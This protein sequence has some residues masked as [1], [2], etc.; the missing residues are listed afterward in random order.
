MNRLTKY[1]ALLLVLPVLLCAGCAGKKAE[2]EHTA[3]VSAVETSQSQRTEEVTISAEVLDLLDL[4]MALTA[5]KLGLDTVTEN[6][7]GSCTVYMTE[8]E[9]AIILEQ[10]ERTLKREIDA[11]PQSGLWPFL[12]K[13]A[14]SEDLKTVVLYTTEDRYTPERDSTIAP[15]VYLPCLLYKAFSGE[16]TDRFK[17][18]F[19]IRN[20]DRVEIDSFRY[21]SPAPA[22]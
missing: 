16:N 22:E 13:I 2:A 21:P 11:L 14:V 7:D 4:D 8:E 6:E 18:E 20:E 19:I 9:K 10:L 15:A 1:M 17:Q 5:R 3:P 12:D